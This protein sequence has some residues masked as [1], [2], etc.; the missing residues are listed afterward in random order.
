MKGFAGRD[1]SVVT[2]NCSNLG[3]GACRQLCHRRTEPCRLQWPDPLISPSD[4]ATAMC[5]VRRA[6]LARHIAISNFTVALTEPPVK[7]A[8]EPLVCKQIEVHPLIDQSKVI[9]ADRRHRMATV[10]Y[11]P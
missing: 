3:S 5:R 8:D 6:G 10:A 2:L 9:A 1:A 11:S 7:L 4:T